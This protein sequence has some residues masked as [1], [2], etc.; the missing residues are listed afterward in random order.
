M[1]EEYQDTRVPTEPE[2]NRA[3][4]LA[5]F[6]VSGPDH[7]ELLLEEYAAGYVW[8]FHSKSLEDIDQVRLEIVGARSF[9]PEKHAFRK[10][11]EFIVRWSAVRNLKAGDQTEGVRFFEFK[12]DHLEFGN[13]HGS[14]ELPWPSGDLGARRRWLLSLRVIGLSN[15]W[16]IE[17]DVRWA[18][19]TQVLE[20]VEYSPSADETPVPVL[21]RP[22]K[23]VAG[24][25]YP[26]SGPIVTTPRIA[27]DYS[28]DFP[29]AAQK[30]VF[31][32][33]VRAA[34][35]FDEKRNSIR[36]ESDLE[37]ARL[38]FLLSIFGAYTKETLE[39][40]QEGVWAAERCE[41]EC[42]KLL[43]QAAGDVRLTDGSA[44]SSKLQAKI[45]SS[46]EWKAYRRQLREV[47]DSQATS[48]ALAAGRGTQSKRPPVGA[49]AGT[50]EDPVSDRAQR[51]QAFVNPI[52]KGKPWKTGKLAT[53]AGVS[54]NSVYQ[55]LDG[56]RA[57]ISAENRKAIA[58]ALG[59]NPVELPE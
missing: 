37:A 17:L 46:E 29:E 53:V 35:V 34:D 33:Q 44:I 2:I 41:S 42:L 14:G 13:T 56:T 52:L 1:V 49:D 19:G 50:K 24:G 45:E 20:I 5:T 15:E 8:K 30:R 54:K 36:S 21:P 31:R 23:P 18:L 25:A 47:A 51:R 3:K 32:E 48:P 22:L 43:R 16:P 38:R 58:E 10:S 27:M 7:V 57:K 4:E 28:K 6:R 26:P 55:Y 59:V 40:G 11:R 39:L 9:D 12:V